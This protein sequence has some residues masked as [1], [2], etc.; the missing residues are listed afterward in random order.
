MIFSQLL[1]SELDPSMANAIEISII[2]GTFR[3]DLALQ[4][5][6]GSEGDVQV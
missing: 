3:I 4:R 2:S 1:G 6:K 5:E